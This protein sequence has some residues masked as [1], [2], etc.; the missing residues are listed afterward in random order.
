MNEIF[1]LGHEKYDLL[2]EFFKKFIKICPEIENM[3]K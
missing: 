2:F 3:P 1:F